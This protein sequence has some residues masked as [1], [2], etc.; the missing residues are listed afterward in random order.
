M[1][2]SSYIELRCHLIVISTVIAA[3]SVISHTP[4][5]VASFER[6]TDIIARCVREVAA[7]IAAEATIITSAEGLSSCGNVKRLVSQ[8]VRAI[9][10]SMYTLSTLYLLV[11]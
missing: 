10:V 1:G 3:L 7:D 11:L 2:V 4:V 8:D 9:K 6:I 5:A